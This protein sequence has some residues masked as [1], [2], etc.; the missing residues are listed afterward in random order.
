MFASPAAAAEPDI[1]IVPF[2]PPLRGTERPLRAAIADLTLGD[3]NFSAMEPSLQRALA[4]QL[5][6]TTALLQKFGPVQKVEFAGTQDG[7]DLYTVTFQNGATTW[8]IG[9]SPAGKVAVLFFRPYL[10]PEARGEDVATAGMSGTLLK[11]D[12]VVAPPVVLLMAGSGPT[13]RNGNQF[14]AGPGELRQLAEALAANGI[15]SLRFDKRGIGRSIDNKLREQDMSFDLMVR[16]AAAWLTWLDGRSDLGR[17][18][19]A[20]HSEGG[21]VAIRLAD[22]APLSGLILLATPGLRLGDSM[23]DQIAAAGWPAA[24][25]DEAL[26]IL[27]KLESGADVKDV[28]APLRPLFRPSVQPF[29]RSELSINPAAELRL[30]ATPTLVVSGGHDLQVGEPD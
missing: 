2:S 28:A 5:Q 20:G 29:L 12:G 13:D 10:G 14:G 18:L 30:V 26:A 8:G 7:A 4:Q 16:D 25:R 22:R 23:R 9:V 19:V 27:A 1:S 21:V 6:A 17:R 24:L 15:A 3:P 11:P